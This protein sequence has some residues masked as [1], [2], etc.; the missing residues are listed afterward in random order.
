MFWKGPVFT[1]DG[2]VGKGIDLENC[3]II[4]DIDGDENG[5]IIPLFRN[6]HTHLGDTLARKEIPD[7]LSLREL[8]GPNGWKHKWLENN[9]Q[10]TSAIVGLKEIINSGTGLVMDF[11]EGGKAGLEIF[12]DIEYP[13]KLILLGRPID[14]EELPGSNA[15]ISSL[16]DI[17]NA[18]EI[19]LSARGKKGLI[20]IHH[21]ENEREEVEPLLNLNP[22]FAVHMCHA[23]ESDLKKIKAKNIS[24][25]VCPRSNYYF[26][27]K[28]PLEKMIEL[29]IDIGF[30]T[31][32]GMLCTA[33]MMDEI[34]FIRTEYESL[35]LKTILSIAC[36]GLDD[37]FNKDGTSTYSNLEQSGWI[38]L[39]RVEEDN[40]ESI[41]NP[42]AEIL[43]IRWR[44]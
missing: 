18:T 3:S 36:F 40:Y 30:G 27:N 11:R 38:L 10:K 5:I 21:S 34:H 43:G 35:E 14:N 23:T 1:R 22:D 44:N 2:F 19:A 9:N 12:D 37:I 6:C 17:D 7:N 8:V 15:G 24:I 39:S 25:V 42:N 31:D 29:E 33:D 4:N 41:F 20:G 32:N 26:G 13:G 28:P 16:V